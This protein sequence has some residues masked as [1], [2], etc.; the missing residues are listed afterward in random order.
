MIQTTSKQRSKQDPTEIQHT[1]NPVQ[2]LRSLPGEHHLFAHLAKRL[3]HLT[4]AM[5]S[6]PTTATM[7][8]T[9][10]TTTS[11][12]GVAE[13]SACRDP[14]FG[15]RAS[16]DRT[17]ACRRRWWRLLLRPLPYRSAAADCPRKRLMVAV[18]AASAATSSPSATEQPQ[19]P[20]QPL[21]GAEQETADPMMEM[22]EAVDDGSGKKAD[23]DEADSRASPSAAAAAAEPPEENAEEPTT[24]KPRTYDWWVCRDEEGCLYYYHRFGPTRFCISG[25]AAASGQSKA[26][27]GRRKRRMRVIRRERSDLL[28]SSKI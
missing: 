15:R 3:V 19:Q 4:M 1:Q 9:T 14:S 7:T 23:D 8:T 20:Q 26:C 27:Q 13:R 5:A 6:A 28:D 24:K 21:N 18:V 11:T 22:D 10:T 17:G 12:G 16:A 25:S 2:K